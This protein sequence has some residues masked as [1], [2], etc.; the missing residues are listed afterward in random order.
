MLYMP[1]VIKFYEGFDFSMEQIIKLQAFYSISMLLFEIPSGYSSDVLGRRFTLIIGTICG[2]IGFSIYTISDYFWHFAIAEV[3][4][5]FGMSFV[6]G[7]D[8]AMLYDSLFDLKKEK[9]YSKYEGRVTATGNYA[10]ALAGII[11]GI[12]AYVFV[13]KYPEYGLQSIFIVQSVI[14]FT[15]IPAAFLLIEPQRHSL[16]KK[17]AL[18]NIAKISK[19]CMI[20]SKQL[21]YNILFSALIGSAT[22]TMAWFVQKLFLELNLTNEIELGFLWAALN[23][24]VGTFTLFAYK[25]DEKLG[26]YKTMLLI[27]LIIGISYILLIFDSG[28]YSL[29]IIFIFYFI[30]GIATPVL[31]DYINKIT[32]SEIR[33]T[34]LS[35]RSFIIRI[36]FS[37]CGPF[38]GWMTDVLDLRTA[39][40]YTGVFYLTTSLF[41]L[42][43][44]KKLK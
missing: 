13:K 5:G 7:S 19:H 41:L 11:G 8:S 30:R 4:M 17:E 29:I 16:S 22:L 20:D 28:L 3:V 24:A 14:S 42:Y 33:A 37:I 35:I 10:E 2:F 9:H 43:K 1:V 36:I 15:G 21:R 12:L 32:S 18:K 25:V 39:L 38:I 23:I 27:T 26:S 44:M 40:C 31:K 6:S 34:V